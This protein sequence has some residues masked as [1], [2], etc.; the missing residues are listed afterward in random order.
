METLEIDL[1]EGIMLNGV[2]QWVYIRSKNKENPVLLFLHGG[3]GFPGIAAAQAYQSGLE[4]KFTVVQWDQRGAGKSYSPTIPK[5]SMNVNQFIS[6]LYELVKYLNNT[7][8]CKKV[9][10]MGHSW[11]AMLG[12]LAVKKHPELFHCFIGI[13]QSVNQKLASEARLPFL[14]EEAKK[15]GDLEAI[16][17]IEESKGWGFFEYEYSVKFGGAFYGKSDTNQLGNVFWGINTLYT[18]IEKQSIPN[19][20]E[21]SEESLWDEI[22][23]INLMETACQVNIPVL[24]LSGKHD[25]L[26]PT[27]V[28]TKY[29]EALEA[30]AKKI[31]YFEKSAHFPFLEENEYFC[32]I[33]NGID[34]ML[35]TK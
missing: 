17:K 34:Q 12:I 10:L 4:N 14:L 27:E 29:Y 19:G 25:K 8:N 1:L 35:L 2:K 28:V 31:L 9:Y 6:D 20:L 13:G 30:P 21:F 15:C 33:I 5:E 23:T 11:G 3:P 24:F 16:Q 18:D 7:L 26:C 22:S 32:K